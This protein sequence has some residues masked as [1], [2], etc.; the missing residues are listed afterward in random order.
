MLILGLRPAELALDPPP[1]RPSDVALAFVSGPLIRWLEAIVSC[2]Q[3]A[4]STRTTITRRTVR[5]VGVMVSSAS[6]GTLA[7]GRM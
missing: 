1:P 4:S 7:S 5:G 2:R 3:R 6:A